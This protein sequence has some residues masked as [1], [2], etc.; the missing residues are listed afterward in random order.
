MLARIRTR[1]S[2]ECEQGDCQQ[3]DRESL[4]DDLLA[5]GHSSTSYADLCCGESDVFQDRQS[6]HPP[7]DPCRHAWD[8]AEPL[9]RTK[10]QPQPRSH[11]SIKEDET[12]LQEMIRSAF[13]KLLTCRP[14]C[15]AV[16]FLLQTPL[17][18]CRQIA[19]QKPESSAFSLLCCRCLL[20]SL[21][22]LGCLLS[23]CHLLCTCNTPLT[24]QKLYLK[25]TIYTTAYSECP[26][27]E[28]MHMPLPFSVHT[29]SAACWS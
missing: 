2:S 20:H 5:S 6:T 16:Y 26:L 11:S 14:Q 22:R 21:L 23:L 24:H 25:R 28:C 17:A 19:Q 18:G 10:S 15:S 27:S 9:R 1:F 3:P 7:T 4:S 29:A 8:P 13:V 12:V